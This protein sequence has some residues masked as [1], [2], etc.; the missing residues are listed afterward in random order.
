MGSYSSTQ[1]K[2]AVQQTAGV[3]YIADGKPWHGEPSSNKLQ[4]LPDTSG[5]R[6][7][8]D[9][10]VEGGLHQGSTT[11]HG[12]LRL[13]PP[14]SKNTEKNEVGQKLRTRNQSKNNCKGAH[15]AGRDKPR[16]ATKAHACPPPSSEPGGI[17][18]VGQQPGHAGRRAEG[19]GAPSPPPG[20]GRRRG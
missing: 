11:E 5:K 7:S 1:K 16:W 2:K 9:S 10:L 17:A 3:S 8:L 19:D 13:R 4:K 18:L 6:M 14:R 20:R 12:W 15:P